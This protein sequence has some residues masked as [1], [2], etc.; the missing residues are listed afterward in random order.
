MPEEY[1]RAIQKQ[2]GTLRRRRA[3]C[4]VSM[5]GSYF[6]S[7]GIRSMRIFS[8]LQETRTVRQRE[9]R[10]AADYILMRKNPSMT[11][12]IVFFSDKVAV[13]ADTW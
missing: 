11:T 9:L 4:F 8:S 6:L 13:I 10:M 1:F 12:A 2:E 7:L 3:C 5:T